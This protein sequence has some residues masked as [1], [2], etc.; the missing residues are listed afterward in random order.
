MSAEDLNRVHRRYVWIS[1]AFKSAWTYHQFLQGVRKVFTH[2]EP[3]EYP[4]NFQQLYGELKEVSQNLSENTVAAASSQLEQIEG[5][6]TPLTDA[7]LAADD[8]ISPGQLRMFFQRVK[9]FDDG[10]LAHLV[11]FYLYSRNNGAWDRDRLDKAD[12]LATKL[13]E[14]YHDDRN[15]FLLRDRTYLRETAEGF[16]AALGSQQ[17]SERKVEN[18]EE[19]IQALGKEFAAADSIDDLHDRG[20]VA[21]Y[22]ELKHRLGDVFFQPQ[23]LQAILEANLALKNQIHRLYRREEQ[24]II[25]EYQQVFELERDAPIDLELGAEL[26]EFRT[27]VDRFEEQLQAENVRLE[28]LAKL[29]QRVRELVPKLQPPT[30][31]TDTGAF[32]PPREARAI[33]AGQA[34]GPEPEE[35]R[36]ATDEEYT[37]EHYKAIV[38]ALDDTNPTLDAR[39]VALQP[40]IF[41]LGIA[42][43]EIIAYRRIYSGAVCD[44][45]LEEFVLRSAALRSRI[46]EEVEDIKSILDDTAVTR[47][48]PQFANARATVRRA[49]LCLREFDHRMEVAVLDADHDE[50]RALQVLKMRMMR[51]FSGLWLMVYRT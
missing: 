33:R 43:R 12:F 31:V 6:L 49:D 27:A 39:K 46:E 45:P 19:R 18:V 51:A 16:W 24:S 13:A 2:L 22:R 28:E 38:A 3:S 10:I 35:I 44:R 5:E 50:A 36:P 41:G 20:L 4:A 21:S 32:V 47:Q 8:E 37:R 30:D 9:S 7:L 11:K 48:A 15:A 34:A 1:N 42:P 23:V 14:E 17:L 29:R 25:A 40:D 26:S